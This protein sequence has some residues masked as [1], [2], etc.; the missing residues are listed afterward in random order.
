MLTSLR[1]LEDDVLGGVTG[2]RLAVR[3]CEKE[4]PQAFHSVE[5]RQTIKQNV[6]RIER[7]LNV[8][9]QA[10]KYKDSEP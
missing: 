4:C 5:V 6:S 2:I 1:A 7:A 3:H 9:V 8:Y 10:E